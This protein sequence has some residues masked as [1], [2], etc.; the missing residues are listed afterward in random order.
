MK[1]PLITFFFALFLLI[2]VHSNAH[3]AGYSMAMIMD[4][5]IVV[6]KID[7]S[8]FSYA[9]YEQWSAV[10]GQLLAEEGVPVF[11]HQDLGD[12]DALRAA[13]PAFFDSF[14]VIFLEL[15]KGPAPAQYASQ[16]IWISLSLENMGM[17]LASIGVNE[18]LVDM[19]DDF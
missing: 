12:A 13:M 10:L 16:N 18:Q 9:E 8:A 1:K 3:S 17:Y 19:L 4:D 6:A 14:M 2:G 11:Y 5:L 7:D 15:T